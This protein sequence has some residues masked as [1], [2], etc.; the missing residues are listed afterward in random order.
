MPSATQCNPSGPTRTPRSSGSLGSLRTDAAIVVLA[1]TIAGLA[2]ARID[3]SETL[4]DVTRTWEHLQL[5]ELPATLL[6]LAIGLTWFASR[7]Y[8][9]A[10]REVIAR[11]RAE[12][13]LENLLQ[14]HRHLAQEFV[15]LQESERKTLARELHDELGQYLIAIKTDACAIEECVAG[16]ASA[17]RAAA[18]IVA[19]SDHVQAIVRH[20]IGRLRPVGLDVLGL[21][22]ALDHL[23][24]DTQ[25]R[26]PSWRLTSAIEGP[27]DA[28]DEAASLTIYRLVQEGLTNIAKHSAASA[29]A[30]SVAQRTLPPSRTEVI[31]VV[32]EDDGRGADLT[33]RTLGLGLRGMRERV[34]MLSGSLQISSV[35]GSGFRISARIPVPDPPLSNTPIAKPPSA[36]AATVEAPVTAT[37]QAASRGMPR[38]Q[39]GFAGRPSSARSASI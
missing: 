8:R 36:S 3:L 15:Q 34:E 2:F 19:H 12:V 4:F 17:A 27:L 38:S 21:Q 28:V 1:T 20:L 14:Q 25:R 26:H 30:V 5:D 11:Q 39:A 24:E 22:A 29:I 7:R 9:E 6:V 13:E 10:R 32:I 31:E 16:N 18:S 37:S 23:L 33:D 35:P